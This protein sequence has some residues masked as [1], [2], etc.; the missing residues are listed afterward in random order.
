LYTPR[1]IA[2]RLGLKGEAAD[3]FVELI[4]LPGLVREASF[5]TDDREDAEEIIQWAFVMSLGA[6]AW[7][8]PA[9]RACCLACLGLWLPN[10][11]PP[12]RTL[13]DRL[14]SP[15]REIPGLGVKEDP[16]GLVLRQHLIKKTQ[17]AVKALDQYDT[18]KDE[19][20]DPEWERWCR[21]RLAEYQTMLVALDV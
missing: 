21:A 17:D 11:G 19:N 8:M 5:L 3:F 9:N 12:G 13:L 16:S 10:L 2:E 6:R 4:S 20:P 15:V 14:S 7:N 18:E 1:E